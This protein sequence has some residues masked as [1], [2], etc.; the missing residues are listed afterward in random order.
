M[1]N[2]EDAFDL[3]DDIVGIEDYTES[4][5]MLVY[6]DPGIGKTRFAGAAKTLF[7]ATENGT[8]SARKA[9]GQ[10]KVW[11]CV[12]S[13]EKFEQAYEWLVDNTAKDGFP[14]D[15]ICIDTVTQLQL[16]IRRSIVE[17]RFELKGGS[18]DK[19]QLEE[20]GEDQMRLMRFVTLVNDLPNVNKLWTAHSM[21]V[22]NE[23]GEEFRLPNMHGQ[24][25]KVAN[26]V[27]A[28]MHCVGYMHFANVTNA[29][30]QKTTKTRVIQWHGTDDVI[31]KDRF[32]C[33]GRQTVNKN[34]AQI[35]EKIL[36]ANAVEDDANPSQK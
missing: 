17:E 28:Q 13:W 12:N 16:N 14:F 27:A 19:V 8:I 3:P 29:K 26:W 22:E 24:G 18:L 21:L 5:S 9:G 20:Y 15:W 2:P 36:A 35:T 1:S 11:D 32:D 31:A 4:I 30:T 33:L 23:K 34:L 7:L 10:S 25:Y 6:G